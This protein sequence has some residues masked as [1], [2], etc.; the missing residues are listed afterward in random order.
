MTRKP[1]ARESRSVRLRDDEWAL[2]EAIAQ[3]NGETGAGHGIRT[4][5]IREAERIARSGHGEEL[6]SARHR[7]LTAR[8]AHKK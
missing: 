2:A 4:A 1:P 6:T 8:A 7:L 3:L 5:L